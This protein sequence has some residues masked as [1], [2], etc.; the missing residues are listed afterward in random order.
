MV[1]TLPRSSSARIRCDREERWLVAGF[2][3]G[4]IAVASGREGNN[5]PGTNDAACAA[6]MAR[7][8]TP[9]PRCASPRCAVRTTEPIVAGA[10]AS[11]GIVT[12][13][14]GAMSSAVGSALASVA[15]FVP[16]VVTLRI[17]SARLTGASDNEGI[18]G[19]IATSDAGEGGATV[20][21]TPTGGDPP[22]TMGGK[23]DATG[24][25]AA[26]TVCTLCTAGV[27]LVA[28]GAMIGVTG[29]ATVWSVA[30]TGEA[31]GATACVTGVTTVVADCVTVRTGGA[32][33]LT[34]G[35]TGCTTDAASDGAAAAAG[36][37]IV[38]TDWIAGCVT[39]VAGCDVTA[40][41]FAS[42]AAS[43]L[44]VGAALWVR[45]P[46]TCAAGATVIVP[47]WAAGWA[48][49]C[50]GGATAEV[51]VSVARATASVVVVTACVAASLA[52][53]TIPASLCRAA[54]DSDE[55]PAVP[56]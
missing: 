18:V 7:G 30:V 39:A 20:E 44:I 24:A 31:I 35:A 21:F 56:G 46:T 10:D 36:C 49:A 38:V 15:S 51:A 17:I 8:G 48:T 55:P 13:E 26:M 14:G 2:L 22:G 28:T 16:G 37:V 6:R 25:M 53:R 27:R 23:L 19:T 3:A 32:M 4:N 11:C 5:V 47:A 1:G 54:D 43:A 12:G 41:V 29:A 45:E 52:P 33:A 9:S 42:G 40:A 34:T 50:T